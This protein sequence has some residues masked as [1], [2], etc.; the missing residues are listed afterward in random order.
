MGEQDPKGLVEELRA[1]GRVASRGEKQT[2]GPAAHGLDGAEQFL[3]HPPVFPMISP[4]D[5]GNI[6]IS[7]HLTIEKQR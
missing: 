3:L 5:K 4:P 6:R 2:P 1:T 7:P